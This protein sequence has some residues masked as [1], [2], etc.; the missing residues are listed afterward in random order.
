[1]EV[2]DTR[3]L[4]TTD[5]EKRLGQQIRQLRLGRNLTQ[6]DLAHQANIDR[7]TVTR[8]EKGEGGSLKSLVQIARVLGREEWLGALAPPTPS[9]SPIEQLRAR[10]HDEG[11]R[12]MR[13]RRPRVP[14]E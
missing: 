12:R 9:V 10:E 14:K 2:R 5:W 11:R 8:I 13:A 7:T 1:M 3:S 6:D 4:K